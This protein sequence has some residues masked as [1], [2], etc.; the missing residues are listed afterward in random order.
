[1]TREQAYNAVHNQTMFD[2]RES[3]ALV[4]ALK[5]LGLLKFDKELSAYDVIFNNV[6][7][8]DGWAMNIYSAL[9]DKGFIKCP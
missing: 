1:M 3:A 8:N 5:I 4:Y 6:A 2:E 9:K 7:G